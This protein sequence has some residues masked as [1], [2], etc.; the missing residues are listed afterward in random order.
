MVRTQLVSGVDLRRRR[1]CGLFE[2]LVCPGGISF[3]LGF[4]GVP[5]I[6]LWFSVAATVY[7]ALMNGCIAAM[8]N[9]TVQIPLF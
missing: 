6:F 9:K 8:D 4:F 7:D 5:D 1:S 2:L 3:S